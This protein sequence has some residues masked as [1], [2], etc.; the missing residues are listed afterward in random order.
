M[1][2]VAS[3]AFCAVLFLTGSEYILEMMLPVPN[4]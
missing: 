2:P 3:K 4:P 1:N